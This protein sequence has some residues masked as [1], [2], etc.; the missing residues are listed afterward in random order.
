ML[1]TCVRKGRFGEGFLEE[2]VSNLE[3]PDVGVVCAR[4][5]DRRGRLSSD[6]RMAGVADS[7]GKSLEGLKKSCTGYFHR[8]VLQQEIVEAT[9]CFLVKAGLF[10][11]SSPENGE[12]GSARWCEKIRNKGYRVV[13]DPWAVLYEEG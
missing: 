7:F 9:D 6:V 2:L 5:Y 3:R 10:C 1:F 8:A 13:Y 12:I 4:V 11:S